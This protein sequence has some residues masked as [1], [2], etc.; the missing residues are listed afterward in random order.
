MRSVPVKLKETD[1]P[2]VIEDV[3]SVRQDSA[4]LLSELTLQASA[5]E[6]TTCEFDG[7]MSMNETAG[8]LDIEIETELDEDEDKWADIV[9]VGDVVVELAGCAL[10]MLEVGLDELESVPEEKED[11]G[12]ELVED[13]ASLA[14]Y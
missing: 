3:V 11:D 13:V 7:L 1:E 6:Y 14:S 10:V 4:L 2:G 5:G 12:A 8:L 9:V